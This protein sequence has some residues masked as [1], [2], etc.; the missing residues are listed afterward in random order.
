MPSPAPP[1]PVH[2][3]AVAKVAALNRAPVVAN[4]SFVV[5]QGTGALV[6]KAP[7]VLAGAYDP[8]NDTLAISNW[9][10]PLHATPGA[11][12][13]YAANG[14][15]KYTPKA[16]YLGADSFAFTVADGNGGATQGTVSLTVISERVLPALV[17]WVR[18][19]A[20][21]G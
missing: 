11:G 10:S 1:P 7:G 3:H 9:T 19:V 6:V 17:G 18:W 14:S 13:T 8:D 2:R 15:F 20:G 12:F 5:I 4:A 16:G 21:W